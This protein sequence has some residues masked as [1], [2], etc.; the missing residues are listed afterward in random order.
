MDA[1]AIVN[2]SGLGMPS[3]R[4]FLTV[5]KPLSI[6]VSMTFQFR[7]DYYNNYGILNSEANPFERMGLP[8]D[9][10]EP[11]F[12]IKEAVELLVMNLPFFDRL[13]LNNV[14]DLHLFKGFLEF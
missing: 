12:D 1:I 11:L 2:T 13:W 6:D 8:K 7:W 9:V 3:L 5:V 10:F 14:S 4:D